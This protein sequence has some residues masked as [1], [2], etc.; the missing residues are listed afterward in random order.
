MFPYWPHAPFQNYHWSFLYNNNS[1]F[2]VSPDLN[3]E[4][5]MPIKAMFIIMDIP[6]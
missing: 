4:S 2:T 1:S 3:T 6:L 5:I